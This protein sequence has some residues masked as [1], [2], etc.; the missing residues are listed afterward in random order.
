M[1]VVI[2]PEPGYEG[3]KLWQPA[4]NDWHLP[5]LEVKAQ[6]EEKGHEV[7]SSDYNTVIPHQVALYCGM[8][9]ISP[10]PVGPSVCVQLEPPIVPNRARFYERM[11]GL[12]FTRILTFVREFVDNKRVFHEVVPAMPYKGELAPVRDLYICAV[13]GGGKEFPSVVVDGKTYESLFSARRF[14]YLSWGKD[15]DLYGR[16]W[17]KDIEIMNVCNYLGPCEDKIKTMSRYKYAIVFENTADCY[18]SE[19]Y[20]DAIQAGCVPLY[21][22]EWPKY[23]LE[24]ADYRNWAKRIVKHLEDI[25]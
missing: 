18:T 13:S 9:S 6:L 20:W 22:G 4:R 23:D 14:A 16:G 8:H 7:T 11:G 12:P 17:E 21:R 25:T 5:Y 1:R 2:F 15:L 24:H 19:K 10:P 3:E